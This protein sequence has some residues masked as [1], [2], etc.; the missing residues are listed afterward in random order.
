MR[1]SALA[2]L[3]L[4]VVLAGCSLVGTP[5]PSGELTADTAPPGVSADD[6][7]LTDA[8]ALL[9][10]HV[11]RLNA[12]GFVTD[13]RVNSTLVR[14][15]EP[16]RVSRRQ[17]VRAEAGAVEYNN[18]VLNPGSRFD[19]WGNR[20]MQVVRLEAAGGV[21]YSSGG[22]QSVETLAGETLLARYLSTGDWT[23]ANTT[24]RNGTTLHTLRSTTLPSSPDAV[25]ANATDVRDYGAVVVV[26]S[27]G[28]IHYFEATADYSID[29]ADGSFL[30]RQRLVSADGPSVERPAWVAEAL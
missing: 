11:T 21:R 5:A 27:A 24:V 3:C 10:A 23:V 26:D 28:R 14:N 1:R 25:P 13:V 18:T 17:V 9:A 15:S 6:G 4:L 16:Q 2:A 20:T 29:G 30:V 7:T 19:V 12:S 22:A 8:D